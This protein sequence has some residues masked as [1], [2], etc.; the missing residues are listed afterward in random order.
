MASREVTNNPFRKNASSSSKSHSLG[1][2]SPSLINMEIRD[3]V[4]DD[5]IDL[6]LADQANYD[7]RLDYFEV[8]FNAA[9][10]MI[11]VMQK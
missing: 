8:N 6:L 11:E 5:F 10:L 4:L 9:L 2:T 3:K 1:G 7:D